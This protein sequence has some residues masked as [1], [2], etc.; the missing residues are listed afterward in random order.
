MREIHT[1]DCRE[2][3]LKKKP[4]RFASRAVIFNQDKLLMLYLSETNE[5]KF[6]G[7]GVEENETNEDALIREAAEEAGVR[8]KKIHEC[9]GYIDQIYPDIYDSRK[10]FYMRSL[11]YLCDIYDD[12]I[13]QKLSNQELSLGYK[14]I[15]VS[16]DEAIHI[17]ELRIKNGS[18]YHWTKRELFMLNYL[19]K[20][21][22]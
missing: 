15:W 10:T 3:K 1:F 16:L 20:T 8:I 13:K 5:Y 9:L 22:R 19:K 17:N 4:K 6:P 18:D 2:I 14:P 11:Y 21:R 12:F 7:G